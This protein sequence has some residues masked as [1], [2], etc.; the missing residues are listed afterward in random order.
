[1][2]KSL[3]ILLVVILFSCEKDYLIP[4]GDVPGWLKDNIKQNEKIIRESP[5]LMNNYG[6]WIRYTWQNESYFEYHNTLSSSMPMPISFS[7]DTLHI[8]ATD[9]NTEYYKGKCC[10]QYVWKAPKYIEI[11]K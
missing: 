2:K 6:A 4:A 3:Y 10:K 9:I 7:Q 1:M 5:H 11:V 8:Y